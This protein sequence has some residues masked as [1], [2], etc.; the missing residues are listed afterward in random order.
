MA[1]LRLACLASFLHLYEQYFWLWLECTLGSKPLPQFA[2]GRDPA[3][4][5]GSL[6]HCLCSLPFSES[7][8]GTAAFV[9]PPRVKL[10]PVSSSTYSGQVEFTLNSTGTGEGGSQTFLRRTRT[11][12]S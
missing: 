12:S 6:P 1:V 8:A 10:A 7:A 4:R 3:R 11:I 9:L 5:I 2:H